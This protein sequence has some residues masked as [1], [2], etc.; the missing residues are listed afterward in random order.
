MVHCKGI[1]EP[2]PTC[3]RGTKVRLKYLQAIS[4]PLLG[5][6]L[7][8]SR[9]EALGRTGVQCTTFSRNVKVPHYE[10][11]CMKRYRPWMAN[12]ILR[13]AGVSPAVQQ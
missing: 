7:A 1:K 13:P 4:G 9:C 8:T 10:C 11:V 3:G 6:H 5:P 2:F 12:S